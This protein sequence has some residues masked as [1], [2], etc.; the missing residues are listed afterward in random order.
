MD[1]VE[2]EEQRDSQPALL[3][4][5]MLQALDHGHID[6][7]QHRAHLSVADE[8]LGREVLGRDW[9]GPDLG[10]LADLLGE[11][12]LR[13]QGLDAA[14]DLGIGDEC[15]LERGSGGAGRPSGKGQGGE[16]ETAPQGVWRG[17]GESGKE[18][19]RRR[20]R[21]RSRTGEAGE[22]TV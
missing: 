4:S 6:R 21:R 12:H 7:P 18:H 14:V 1:H 17:R 22:R 13:E 3:H 5:E 2:T 20:L 10:E 11:G 19:G 9:I 16:L 15:G 8:V